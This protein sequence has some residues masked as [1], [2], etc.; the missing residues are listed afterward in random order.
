MQQ[1]VQQ[2]QQI[3]QQQQPVSSSEFSN[4]RRNCVF[5]KFRGMFTKPNKMIFLC[6]ENK[7]VVRIEISGRHIRA[8]ERFGVRLRKEE[9]EVQ[10]QEQQEQQEQ[11]QQQK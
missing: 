3:Q 4:V 1:Q 7:T 8:L 2:Q 10:Q 6:V 11:Q 5:D 9:E